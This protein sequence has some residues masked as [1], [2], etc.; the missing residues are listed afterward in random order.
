MCTRPHLYNRSMLCVFSLLLLSPEL[1][2]ASA[3]SVS[4][5]ENWLWPVCPFPGRPLWDCISLLQ[6][7]VNSVHAH[8]HG[9]ELP[10]HYEHCSPLFHKLLASWTLC[11]RLWSSWP[12]L[13]IYSLSILSFISDERLESGPYHLLTLC[14]WARPLPSPLCA[15]SVYGRQ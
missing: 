4:Q 1:L 13:Y 11:T 3:V 2:E 7:A 5:Q 10:Q 8:L 9:V 15:S 6:Q 14:C 12:C